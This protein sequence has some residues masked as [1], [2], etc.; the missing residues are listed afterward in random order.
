MKH[1]AGIIIS[2]VI[3]GAVLGQHVA[4]LEPNDGIRLAEVSSLFSSHYGIHGCPT[5]EA[6]VNE[7]GDIALRIEDGCLGSV[8]TLSG[9]YVVNRRTGELR[10]ALSDKVML[11][12]TDPAVIGLW[13]EIE[14]A[15]LTETE[16]ACLVSQSSE[17]RSW[18]EAGIPAS[19]RVGTRQ[20][21]AFSVTMVPLSNKPSAPESLLR[22]RVDRRN[23]RVFEGRYQVDLSEEL[24]AMR[25]LL[26]GSKLPI[27]LS[28]E[29]VLAG[30][31]EIPEVSAWLKSDQ[32]R[33]IRLDEDL[34]GQTYSA[35][36][37][38]RWCPGD[39]A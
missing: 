2:L 13:K 11:E 14:A 4:L 35:I 10:E 26:L 15:L 7:A 31:R 32:C 24:L 8:S 19:Q 29:D 3:K 38:F 39:R 27:Q 37:L 9:D 25:Y 6:G 12:E 23:Y 30:A 36:D 20:D 33:G 1:L 5:A 34:E 28:R 18:R 17:A 22:F 21:G 16:S